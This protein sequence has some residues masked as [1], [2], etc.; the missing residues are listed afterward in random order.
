MPTEQKASKDPSGMRAT[1]HHP[2]A[3][4]PVDFAAAS[5]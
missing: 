3:L 1:R 2:A 4:F 5:S